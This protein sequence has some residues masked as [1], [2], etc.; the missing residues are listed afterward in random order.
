MTVLTKKPDCNFC[1]EQQL[2]YTY[3]A[4]E[5]I[6]TRKHV[7]GGGGGEVGGRVGCEHQRHSPAIA[8]AQSGQRLCYLLIGKYPIKIC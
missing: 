3:M 2:N 8:Y 1:L 6:Y 4:D 5:A 7:F